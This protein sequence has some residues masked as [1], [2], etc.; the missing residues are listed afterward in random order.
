M[1]PFAHALA[2][3]YFN[4]V[5]RTPPCVRDKWEVRRVCEVTH[6][7]HVK[8]ALAEPDDTWSAVH[9]ISVPIFYCDRNVVP[10]IEE[11]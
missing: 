5:S 3:A 7:K 8:T 11:P 10:S 6:G 2:G 9:L 4:L 1:N